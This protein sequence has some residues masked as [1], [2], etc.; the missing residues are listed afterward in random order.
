MFGSNFYRD[1]WATSVQTVCWIHGC[2]EAVPA[3]DDLGLCPGHIEE[4]KG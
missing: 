4:L 1:W 2:K 3:E